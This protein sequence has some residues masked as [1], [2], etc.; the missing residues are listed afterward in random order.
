MDRSELKAALE[1]I[2]ER[3]QKD[4]EFFHKLIF[5]PESIL[6]EL[7]ASRAVKAAVLGLDLDQFWNFI[8][9]P[10]GGV[11]GCGDSC[12][13]A[14]CDDTCGQRSCG[15]TCSDSCDSTCASSCGKTLQLGNPWGDAIH[16]SLSEIVGRVASSMTGGCR[17]R[18][19]WR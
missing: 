19:R 14:S 1:A 17:P 7:P 5:D 18:R 13:W 12:G 15:H 4:P 16:P 10:P 9:R 2:R 6:S 3:A 11:E 8:L